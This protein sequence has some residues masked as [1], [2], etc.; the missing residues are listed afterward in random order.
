MTTKQ[1]LEN[2]ASLVAAGLTP[3][4]R[5]AATAATIRQLGE[6]ASAGDELGLSAADVHAGYAQLAA[7]R[8]G[9]DARIAARRATCGEIT[10]LIEQGSETIP[11]IK[12]SPGA[13]DSLKFAALLDRVAEQFAGS[14][15]PRQI[16]ITQTALREA[17]EL[18]A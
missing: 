2:V 5:A 14:T 9:D 17:T 12:W 16:A 3:P 13:G 10:V 4:A 11:G 8:P 15:D 18:R 6:I 1:V 7:A